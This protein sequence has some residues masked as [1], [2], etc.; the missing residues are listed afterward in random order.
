MTTVSR[1]SRANIRPLVLGP[2]GASPSISKRLYDISGIIL[3]VLCLNFIC[4]PFMLLTVRDSLKAW[5]VLGWY[6][7][8]IIFGGLAAFYGGGRKILKGMHPKLERA[9]DATG[10]KREK[11]S[12]K[13][14]IPDRPNL[15]NG[16]RPVTPSGEPVTPGFIPPFDSAA[17]E[18]EKRWQ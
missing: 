12:L 10:A 11:P 15:M 8:Y 14:G 13:A 5:S 1:L 6:G 9:A 3:T 16:S 7:F 4:T 2:P 17:K 18:A